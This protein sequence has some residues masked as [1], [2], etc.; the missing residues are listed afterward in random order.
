[1]QHAPEGV[2]KFYLDAQLILPGANTGSSTHVFK[3]H[4]YGKVQGSNYFQLSGVLHLHDHII[5]PTSLTVRDVLVEK[6][7]PPQSATNDCFLQEETERP[8]RVIFESIDASV[9]RS[10]PLK[11]TKTAGPSGL[12]AHQC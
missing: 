8:H 3:P 12:D 1:M 9:I 10:A 5:D 11:V 4:V 2:I 6:H 7:P